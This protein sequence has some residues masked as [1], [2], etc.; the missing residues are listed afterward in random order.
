[1]MR[2]W[3][4]LSSLGPLV[5]ESLAEDRASH[6]I[7]ISV[8]GEFLQ[9]HVDLK[10]TH[11]T[12]EIRAKAKGIFSGQRWLNAFQ[13]PAVAYE[14][15][16]LSLHWIEIADEGQAIESGSCVCRGRASLAGVLALERTLLNGLQ[17]ACGVATA[18]AEIVQYVNLE[19]A[20]RKFT[21]P[22]PGIFHT[23][24]TLPGLRTLEL[25]AVLAGGGRRHRI[26]L[27]DRV[28]VKENHKYLAA[29]FHQSYVD[30]ARFVL[31]R[32]PN[33][34]LEV[35]TT[36]EAH[37]LIGVG[38]RHLLLDNF[39]PEQLQILLPQIPQEVEIELSGGIHSGNIFD[40]LIDGVDRISLG[41]LTHSVKALD[42]SLDWAQEELAEI[43]L[44]NATSAQNGAKP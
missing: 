28:L 18:T 30:F 29:E 20:R 36:Q 26:H 17:H 15:P 43:R 40:Y 1:M 4:E 16:G 41:A 7:T 27:A 42:L 6:D 9:S 35:E 23:R 13:A 8:L 21:T 22:V 39:S 38:A 2:D 24:K 31:L 3:S 44:G 32:Y 11:R 34:M 25:E 37:D 5:Q 10:Q 12:F 19:W 33:A 14:M